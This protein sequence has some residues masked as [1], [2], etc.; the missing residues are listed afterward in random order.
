MP[1][2]SSCP[3]LVRRAESGEL[4]EN[5]RLTGDNSIQLRRQTQILLL[6]FHRRGQVLR[7]RNTIDY[8]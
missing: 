2:E 1:C 6:R 5:L 7:Q 3:C 8:V 4:G